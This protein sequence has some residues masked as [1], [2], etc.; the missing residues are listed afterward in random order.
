LP[1]RGFNPG[2]SLLVGPAPFRVSLRGQGGA[3][4]LLN[5]GQRLRRSVFR[6]RLGLKG[7][8]RRGRRGGMVLV[9]LGIKAQHRQRIDPRGG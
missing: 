3:P 1:A 7:L 2:L 4:H 6:P 9:S 5:L 8:Q